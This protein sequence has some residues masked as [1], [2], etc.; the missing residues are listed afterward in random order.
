MEHLSYWE[1][2]EEMEEDEEIVYAW[3]N[4]Y[5]KAYV[6]VNAGATYGDDGL[7]GVPESEADAYWSWNVREG[8]ARR[9]DLGQNALDNIAR[10]ENKEEVRKETVDWLKK[11]PTGRIGLTAFEDEIEAEVGEYEFEDGDDEMM[12]WVGVVNKDGDRY[13]AYMEIQ[14]AAHI[15]EKELYSLKGSIRKGSEFIGEFNPTRPTALSDPLEA[16]S[17]LEKAMRS[18][19]PEDAVME[20]VMR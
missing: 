16:I 3:R 2:N 8:Q 5:T 15:R 9:H 14:W 20:E 11:N 12:S 18:Y 19:D 6:T 1:R 10:G 4:K 17:K 13:L 7:E